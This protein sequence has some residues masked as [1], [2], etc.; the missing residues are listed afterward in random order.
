MAAIQALRNQMILPLQRT[1]YDYWK[2]HCKDG[3][4]PSRDDIDPSDIREHL[5]MLSITSICRNSQRHRFLC[6]L[7]GT[8]F[9]DLYEDEIQGRYIDEL[10]LGD[11][12]DYWH[13]VLTQVV[14]KRK[15]TAGVTRPG[16]P[17]GSHMA[18]FWIRMPLSSDGYN[19]D[20]ILGYDQ[21]IQMS[22]AKKAL[23]PLVKMSA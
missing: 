4:L 5:P 13:R 16:T 11:R 1:L 3:Q 6:R 8:G 9:W 10:P 23:A 22:E 12:C 17:N 14:N 18:Q 19:V 21:L 20:L 2:S 15:A 7:A